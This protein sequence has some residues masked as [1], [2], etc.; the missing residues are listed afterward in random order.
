MYK[1]I[2]KHIYIIVYNIYKIL[3]YYKKKIIYIYKVYRKK[4]NNKY[5]YIYPRL[6]DPK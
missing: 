5:I 4:I 6:S 3:Y 1:K 2:K